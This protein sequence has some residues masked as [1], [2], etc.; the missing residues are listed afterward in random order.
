METI[1]STSE[2]VGKKPM[3]SV[4]KEMTPSTCQP[5]APPK[6]YM[7]ATAMITLCLTKI[8]TVQL[9]PHPQPLN[10]LAALEMTKWNWNS[11]SVHRKSMASEE[12]E[13][14]RSFILTIP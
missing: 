5:G 10:S 2:T 9:G 3:V 12:Q 7:V 6:E 13:M 4:A 11:Y 1:L 14:T 8:T